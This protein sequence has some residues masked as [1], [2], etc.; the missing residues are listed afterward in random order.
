MP[1]KDPEKQKK[2][3][4][5]WARKHRQLTPK[6]L[7]KYKAIYWA[8]FV[9]ADGTIKIIKR[10]P[11][12]GIINSSYIPYVAVSNTTKQIIEQFKKDWDTGTIWHKKPYKSNHKHAYSCAVSAKKCIEIVKKLV[13]YLRVKKERAELLIEFYEK[14]EFKQFGQT[15]TPQHIIDLREEYRQKMLQLNKRGR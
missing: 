2:A 5:E 6:T 14:S 10:K 9:D 4:R 7:Q 13:P 15:G 3:K 8:G 1:Y 12:K 11:L